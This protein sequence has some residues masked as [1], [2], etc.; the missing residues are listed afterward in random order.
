MNRRSVL[1]G[2]T[3]LA[4]CACA[5]PEAPSLTPEVAAPAA[6]GD[7]DTALYQA[8]AAEPGNVFVSPYSV[9]SA[10]TLVY[11]GAGGETAREI[12]AVFGFDRSAQVEAQQWR[13]RADAL[14]SQTGGTQLTIANAAWVEQTMQ[15]R[16]AYARA[17]HDTLNGTIEAVPFIANQPAALRTINAWTSRET[18][19]RIP[20]I[21][22]DEDPDRRL[23]LT[24]AVYFKGKWRDQFAGGDTRDGDF[25]T[26]ADSR[27][28]A[29]LMRQM[30]SARYMETRTF[31]AAELEYDDGVFALAVFLPRERTGIAAFERELSARNLDS[32]LGELA[33]ADRA[34]L[35]LTLPKVEM[36]TSYTLNGAL[37]ALGVRQAFLPEADFSAIT[38]DE[39][40]M[41]SRV[42]HKAF[43]AIDEQGTEAAAVT[44]VEAVAVSAISP[45]P[46]PP[47]AFKAD[48]PF[49][50]V[51]H[52]KPT[53]TRL[54]LG[55]IA[56]V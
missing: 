39:T 27:V 56:T 51:L 16:T 19:G 2:A 3:A 25:F 20:E 54:F 18:Q 8:L 55:R 48:H 40:L 6:D 23:V 5:A 45:Q 24:N 15:L 32:W 22:T 34:R 52:H 33:N 42:V 36:R 41:I 1:L 50:I 30:T 14:R 12:G 38:A 10:F 7:F 37:Q 4:L 21:I 17:I 28:R 11:P 44:A 9:A 35:D 47:V 53:R 26:G 43:L 46:P 49:F 31:Q 13:D 29:R